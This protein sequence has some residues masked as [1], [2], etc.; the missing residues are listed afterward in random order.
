MRPDLGPRLKHTISADGLTLVST[1]ELPE[2]TFTAT[3]TWPDVDTAKANFWAGVGENEALARLGGMR[4]GQ[5]RRARFHETPVGQ[6]RTFLST[7]PPTWWKPRLRLRRRPAKHEIEFMVGWL[8]RAYIVGW[9][10]PR[11]RS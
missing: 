3:L 7:G 11:L 8:R 5:G 2:G 4:V 6:V 9:R 1:G 10:D